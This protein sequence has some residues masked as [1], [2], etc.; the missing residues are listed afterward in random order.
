MRILSGPVRVWSGRGLV[1]VGAFFF[2]SLSVFL[3]F[4]LAFFFSCFLSSFLPSFLLFLLLSFLLSFLSHPESS[5]EFK[6][7]LRE[8]SKNK[9]MFWEGLQGGA[10]GP[11]IENKKK[12]KREERQ[13]EKTRE[14]K[15][16]R[17]C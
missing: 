6:I 3:F 5:L 7:L 9:A 16:K 11:R 1:F 13:T 12:K 4:F 8:M 10:R 17:N 15:K 2:L 14:K